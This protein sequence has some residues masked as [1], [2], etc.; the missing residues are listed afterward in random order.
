MKH[1]VTLY[2]E[3]GISGGKQRQLALLETLQMT[4]FVT[5]INR[6]QVSYKC[7]ASL[8]EEE[9]RNFY[10]ALKEMHH[11]GE[12]FELIDHSK[13]RA[14]LTLEQIDTLC[15]EYKKI[16]TRVLQWE[17]SRMDLEE[18]TKA[19][20]ERAKLSVLKRLQ[21]ADQEISPKPEITQDS[22]ASADVIVDQPSTVTASRYPSGV[23]VSSLFPSNS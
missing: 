12:N 16:F 14:S 6:E 2:P 23:P 22:L 20:Q 8:T 5:N 15:D 3:N 11:Q 9:K 17:I 18:E 7:I 19:V 4:A 1:K 13:I 21:L 10:I